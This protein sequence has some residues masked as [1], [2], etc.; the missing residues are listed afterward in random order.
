MT[1]GR[2]RTYGKGEETHRP[3]V[4]RRFCSGGSVPGVRTGVRGHRYK[5]EEDP[6]SGQT[7]RPQEESGH[8]NDPEC[9]VPDRNES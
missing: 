4:T 2:R 5:E 9:D 6:P 8:R 7:E 3:K 1:V